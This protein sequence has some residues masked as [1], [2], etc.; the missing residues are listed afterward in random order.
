MYERHQTKYHTFSGCAFSNNLVTGYSDFD[1]DQIF[2]I[3]RPPIG[4][5]AT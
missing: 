4:N 1:F 5:C 2:D 3:R